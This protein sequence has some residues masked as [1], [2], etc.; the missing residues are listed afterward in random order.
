M[1]SP[2]HYVNAN[3]KE[4][5]EIEED[6]VEACPKCKEKSFVETFKHVQGP[7]VPYGVPVM[8]CPL[9]EYEEK[10]EE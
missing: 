5:I 10:T 8:Y 4:D 2:S 3:M 6:E 1:K 7:I 9:C